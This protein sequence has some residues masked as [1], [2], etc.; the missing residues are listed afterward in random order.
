MYLA[1]YP[2]LARWSEDKKSIV[3][4]KCWQAPVIFSG[5]NRDVAEFAAALIQAGYGET[6]GEITVCAMAGESSEYSPRYDEA[7]VSRGMEKTWTLVPFGGRLGL[8]GSFCV[9]RV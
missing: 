5:E 4:H 9:K 7:G 8:T 3:D 2:T 6:D 1:H